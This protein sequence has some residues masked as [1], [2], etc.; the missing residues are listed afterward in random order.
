MK[1]TDDILLLGNPQL[2]EKSEHIKFEELPFIGDVINDLHDVMMDFRK[3]YGFGKAI[4]APQIGV[5]KRLIYVQVEKPLIIINP[6]FEYQSHEMFELWDNCMSFPTLMVKLKR[7]KSIRM[8]YKDLNWNEQILEATDSLSELIQHEY[9]HLEG[10]LSTQ[11]AIDDKSL[12]II[13][14]KEYFKSY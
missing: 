13:N 8:K 6:E 7:H 2:Y 1:T 11:R 10:I 3:K 12:K 4:A 9:D 5:K 14:P